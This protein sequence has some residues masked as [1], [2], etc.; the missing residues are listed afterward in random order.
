[1]LTSAAD[2]MPGKTP[3]FGFNPMAFM[4]HLFNH[5][6]WQ[7]AANGIASAILRQYRPARISAKVRHGSR[8]RFSSVVA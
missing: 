5:S 7:Y 3:V 2:T 8:N 6:G 1:M 4:Q